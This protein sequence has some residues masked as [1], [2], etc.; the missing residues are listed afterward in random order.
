MPKAVTKPPS[1]TV[2][3]GRAAQQ[4]DGVELIEPRELADAP[5][6]SGQS[7]SLSARRTLLLM[8]ASAAAEGFTDKSYRLSKRELR[9]GH[10]S[11]D[12]IGDL[13]DEVMAIRLQI[14]GLSTRSRAAVVKAHLL[15]EVTEE[16]DDEDS[17]WV[18]FSF[19]RRA[20]AI[21]E[22]SEAY[23]VL[24]RA[25]VLAFQGKYAVTLYQLGC[26]YAGR[27]DPTLRLTVPDLRSRLGIPE[28]RYSDWA[29][30]RRFVLQP[31]KEEVDHLAHFQVGIR[32][33]REG[34][35]VVAVTFGFWRKDDKA[36]D[37]AAAEIDR[38]KIGRKARQK[39]VVE[40]VVPLQ[41]DLE[42]CIPSPQ[43]S[44]LPTSEA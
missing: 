42:D 10:E 38:P 36:I 34:R 33:H 24:N 21:F 18:E 9:Q 1:R 2:R 32:E 19:S 29:Q 14:P 16:T 37:A 25:A 26:L 39:K 7:P 17:A 15:E 41:L 40:K 8:V 3:V 23:A 35:K 31:A 27:R 5:F 12:R 28:G 6:V 22:G 44:A 13:I 11:N 43:D 30:I 4:H 20:R